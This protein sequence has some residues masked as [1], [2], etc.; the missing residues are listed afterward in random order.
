MKINQSII[1][2]IS[3]LFE[4]A[5]YFSINA[6]RKHVAVRGFDYKP[7]TVKKYLSRQKK[8]GKIFDAGRGWYSSIAEP[9]QLDT[10]SV[11]K[12][13]GELKQAFPLLDFAC[14]STAQLNE[15]LRHQLAKHVQFAYVERDAI[16]SVAEGLRSKG[17][18]TYANPGK[19]EIQRSFSI[20]EST[21]V[22]P[23]T[24]ETPHK[25]GFAT[26]EKIMVDVLAD[27]PS[28]S[29]INI[30]ELIDGAKSLITASRVDISVLNRY[31][32][33]RKTSLSELI[34]WA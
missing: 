30:P 12:L 16:D 22:L 24:S 28:F 25:N 6:L 11:E 33:R 4:Q 17:Y 27:T 10:A 19:Q 1:D 5:P 21:V 3:Q 14:W 23:F 8:E 31:A 9:Y 15:M 20:E 32:A 13:V 29:I 26:I 18:H 2:S 7:D 34:K